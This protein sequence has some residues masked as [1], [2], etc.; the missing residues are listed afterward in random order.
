M[1]TTFNSHSFSEKKWV[2]VGKENFHDRLTS[3]WSASDISS[4][5]FPSGFLTLN[6]VLCSIF[7]PSE[8]KKKVVYNRYWAIKYHLVHETINTMHWTKYLYKSTIKVTLLLFPA[9]SSRLFVSSAWYCNLVTFDACLKGSVKSFSIVVKFL[10][11]VV[12]VSWKSKLV[13]DL[14]AWARQTS[15]TGISY[16]VS[17]WNVKMTMPAEIRIA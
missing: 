4:S 3:H 1:E 10:H 12:Y 16:F 15:Q 14:K 5:A 11:T 8:L 13:R 2:L 7:L 17:K 9:I 6:S